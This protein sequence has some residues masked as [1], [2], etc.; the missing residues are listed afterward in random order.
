[1]DIDVEAIS[2]DDPCLADTNTNL[3]DI[4]SAGSRLSWARVSSTQIA[5]VSNSRVR[6]AVS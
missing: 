4:Y 5:L 6:I 1:M 2:D 3:P